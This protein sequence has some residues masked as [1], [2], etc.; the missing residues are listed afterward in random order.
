MPDS[1]PSRPRHKFPAPMTTAVW[2][3]RPATWRTIAA[4]SKAR[5]GSMPKPCEPASASPPS[6]SRIRLYLASSILALPRKTSGQP[7]G[8]PGGSLDR[9][10]HF[11]AGESPDGDILAGG[12]DD[13]AQQ[14]LHR[15]RFVT[16]V[17]LPQQAAFGV[18]PLEAAGHDLLDHLVGLPVRLGGAPGI[19]RFLL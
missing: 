5:F 12:G 16:Y 10:A 6:L 11:P 4:T 15:L 18:E 1:I 7:L 14:V 9:L 13:L 8:W 17:G 19:L 2:T 3:P